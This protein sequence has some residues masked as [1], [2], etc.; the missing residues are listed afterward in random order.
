MEKKKCPTCNG[1]GTVT[2]EQRSLFGTFM[3]RTTC[4]ECNGKGKVYEKHALLVEVQE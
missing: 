4:T 1:S 2:S 3:T